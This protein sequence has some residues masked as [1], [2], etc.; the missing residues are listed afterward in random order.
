MRDTASP[1]GGYFLI[2]DRASVGDGAPHNYTFQ[3]V[4]QSGLSIDED[5]S[6]SGKVVLTDE[7]SDTILDVHIVSSLGSE[8]SPEIRSVQIGSGWRDIINVLAINSEA[9]EEQFWI[10]MHPRLPGHES[11]MTNFTQEADANGAPLLEVKSAGSESSNYFTLLTDGTLQL[12]TEP[13]DPEAVQETDTAVTVAPDVTVETDDEPD[14]SMEPIEEAIPMS[15]IDLPMET[16]HKTVVGEVETDPSVFLFPSL[17]SAP[18]QLVFRFVEASTTVLRKTSINTCNSYTNVETTTTL[19]T[20]TNYGARECTAVD[21]GFSSND[22]DATET[23]IS[24]LLVQGQEYFAIIGITPIEGVV[25]QVKAVHT[26][27]AGYE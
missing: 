21:G 27:I 3:A 1:A 25:P 15:A 18:A 8:A 4:L 20:C 16:S 9:V 10:I 17:V 14:A 12:T 5:L 13:V 7:S 26:L 11:L 19:V 24:K 22:C 23:G 2:V 6:T